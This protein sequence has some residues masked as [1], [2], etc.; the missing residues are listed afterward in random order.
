MKQMSLATGFE[1][2]SKR[3]RKREFLD[4]MDLVVP[5]HELI[6][7]IESH[8]PPKATGRPAFAV[9]SMLRI[10]LLQ[11]W[12]NL[13]DPAVEE[14][15]YDTPV[16]ASFARLDPGI[17]T[18]P[19]ESTILRFRRLLETHQL[20]LQI[21]ALVNA[22]L[23]DKN[24][25]LRHGTV[26]DATLIAAPSSTKNASGERDPEMHQSKKGNQWHFGMKCHIGVDSNSGLV[27]TVVSTSG[28]EA[29]ISHAHRLLHGQESHALGDSGYQ[30]VDKRA[31]AANSQVS[32]HIAMRKGL[33][34]KLDLGTQLGMLKEKYEQTKASMRAKVEH[35]FRVIKQQFGFNKV[36]YR[37]IA[38][39]DNKLQT[40]FAL[41]NLW[42][43]RGKLKEVQA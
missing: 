34:K 2:K 23:T 25:L 15:L 22:I 19:D 32:W 39:N 38:K 35:P 6:T 36:R 14:A 24:L 16:F 28:N 33:R 4:E 11:Q 10:H 20:G 21:L 30:G 13:S 8:S 31:Q 37:G 43:V 40:M 42:L 26:V 29:D 3:T 9:E 5:W 12:F 7:L 41:A 1:K 17:S 27:H 18:M